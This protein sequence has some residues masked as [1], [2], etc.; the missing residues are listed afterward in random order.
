[1]RLNDSDGDEH[2]RNCRYREGSQD[3]HAPAALARFR[4][5]FAVWV[6]IWVEIWVETR[7]RTNARRHVLSRLGRGE[8]AGVVRDYR[9][10]M[11]ALGA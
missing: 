10:R 7:F 4:W 1:V 8:A 2:D 9:F 3:R 5:R 6:E 11:A